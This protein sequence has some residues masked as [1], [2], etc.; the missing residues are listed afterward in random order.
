MAPLF[1]KYNT[2][3]CYLVL[4]NA[5]LILMID[6]MRQEVTLMIAIVKDLWLVGIIKQRKSSINDVAI[7]GGLHPHFRGARLVSLTTI[8]QSSIII[9][10]ANDIYWYLLFMEIEF[11]V[12]VP[13]YGIIP[14]IQLYHYYLLIFLKL[15][16]F[17]NWRINNMDET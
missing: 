5:N 11:A 2:C 3:K 1:R 10:N 17:N 12:G 4:Y 8:I 16:F 9:M 14:I 13:P 15:Y 7:G 6:T